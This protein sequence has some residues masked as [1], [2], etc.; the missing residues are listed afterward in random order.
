M[1]LN[2]GAAFAALALVASACTSAAPAAPSHAANAELSEFKITLNAQKLAAGQDTFTIANKGTITH[3]FVVVKTDVADNSMPKAPDG[4]VDEEAKELTAVDEQEDIA[5]G[6]TVTLGANL[7]PGNYEYFCNLPGHF[8][9]GMHGSIT[10][11]N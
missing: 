4:G 1:H 3:E 7:A 6:T 10:V 2:R 5:P 9:G 8:A 11:T